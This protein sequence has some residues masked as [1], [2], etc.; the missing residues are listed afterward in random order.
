MYCYCRLHGKYARK[1]V[2]EDE[3]VAGIGGSSDGNRD[4]YG[5]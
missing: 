4:T 5:A 3:V 1:V 2:R